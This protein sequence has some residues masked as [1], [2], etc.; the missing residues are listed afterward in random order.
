MQPSSSSSSAESDHTIA[1]SASSDSLV[2]HQESG[3]TEVKTQGAAFIAIPLLSL[4]RSNS[5][6]M[7]PRPWNVPGGSYTSEKE[8]FGVTELL[9]LKEMN[10]HDWILCN[11]A[12]TEKSAKAMGEFLRS[13][14]CQVRSLKLVNCSWDPVFANEFF[15]GL[16]DN[17][18][19]NS[20]HI[21][22][23]AIS[24]EIATFIRDALSNGCYPL[25]TF[26]LINLT[27]PSEAL[28][29]IVYGIIA[30]NE[31]VQKTIDSELRER[32][33]T[34]Y[35]HRVC[36]R[37]GLNLDAISMSLN[38]VIVKLL[39]DIGNPTMDKTELFKQLV[40]E[41][42]GVSSLS[43]EGC[44]LS[45][46]HG[47][48]ISTL[49]EHSRRLKELNLQG[50]RLG[51]SKTVKQLKTPAARIR[52]NSL[53]QGPS[54]AIVSISDAL[55][56][57]SSLVTLILSS[58]FISVSDWKILGRV[59]TEFEGRKPENSTVTVNLTG[60]QL[61]VKEGHD[62]LIT[63]GSSPRSVSCQ[64]ELDNSPRVVVTPRAR[65]S[66]LI[67]TESSGR[68][69]V[70]KTKQVS[71]DLSSRLPIRNNRN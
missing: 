6:M 61:D 39:Q 40:E 10:K 24:R 28:F 67:A 25:R 9:Q 71:K 62:R 1:R 26:N 19:I 58:N 4:E 48:A 36:Q 60:N 43:L 18:S 53:P 16:Q 46:H 31:H 23:G 41:K 42:V 21:E 13:S 49:I 54:D 29:E 63:Q 15:Y 20:L 44:Q 3:T 30:Q 34:H 32:A 66:S 2:S 52:E 5:I 38:D 59:V 37:L 45:T 55:K 14:V 69:D 17:K 22:G 35:F 56:R 47:R 51:S 8:K 65:S 50:N 7:S 33:D 11:Y 70:A 27:I 68:P 12:F 57:N 64:P